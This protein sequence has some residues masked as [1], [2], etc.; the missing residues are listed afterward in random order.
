MLRILP[1]PILSSPISCPTNLLLLW[2]RYALPFFTL[3]T[4]LTWITILLPF[5]INYRSTPVFKI[6]VPHLFFRHLT[7]Q[8]C[9]NNFRI[10]VKL[11]LST[12]LNHLCHFLEEASI[13]SGFTPFS[14][15]GHWLYI[16]DSTSY[17]WRMPYMYTQSGFFETTTINTVKMDCY[18]PLPVLLLS[19]ILLNLFLSPTVWDLLLPPN[20]ITRQADLLNLLSASLPPNAAL[21]ERSYTAHPRSH[22]DHLHAAIQAVSSFSLD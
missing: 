20:I 18:L 11:L 1:F 19:L 21:P 5:L 8:P 4:R 13:T 17:I 10:P 22:L 2:A 15:H 16:C 9:R 14:L 12:K 6:P 7:E 3:Q